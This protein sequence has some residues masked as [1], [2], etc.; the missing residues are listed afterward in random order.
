MHHSAHAG[1][2]T[3]QLTLVTQAGSPAVPGR[4]PDTLPG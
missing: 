2:A 4:I 1:T 3:D